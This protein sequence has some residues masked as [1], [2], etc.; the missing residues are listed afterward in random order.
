M[1]KEQL[2]PEKSLELIGQMIT[3]ARKEFNDNGFMYLLWG[4]FAFSAA[5]AHYALMWVEYEYAFLPWAVLMPLGGIISAIYSATRGKKQLRR[6][7]TWVDRVM[8]YVWMAIV[9]ALFVTLGVAS[10]IGWEV[11]YPFLI[12]LYGVGTF[13][14]GGI[15]QF[16]PLI[17]GGILCWVISAVAFFVSFDIQLLLLAC[18]LL[19]S[20]IVP[21]HILRHQYSKNV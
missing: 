7:K 21:G 12:L 14:S 18:A 20:Y 19:V 16:R 15:M 1:E 9:L 3:T 8:G 4:W 5:L 6:V 10:R 2:T 17:A 11:S 13:I